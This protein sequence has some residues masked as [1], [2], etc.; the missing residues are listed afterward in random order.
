M[1]NFIKL[2]NNI[3]KQEWL[4][5]YIQYTIDDYRRLYG[6]HVHQASTQQFTWFT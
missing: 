5:H 4:H 3:F 1:N 2:G 6:I